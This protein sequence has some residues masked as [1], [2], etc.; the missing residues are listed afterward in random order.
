MAKELQQKGVSSKSASQ[1]GGKNGKSLSPPAYGVAMPGK[2]SIQRKKK[3][4]EDLKKKKPV[5]R[6]AK[7]DD[8]KKKKPL[9]RKKKEEDDLKKKKPI[10]RKAKPGDSALLIDAPDSPLEKEADAIAE[11]VVQH[12]SAPGSRNTARSQAPISRASA[13]AGGTGALPAPPYLASELEASRGQGQSLPGHLRSEMEGV[14]GTD[15]SGV[16]IHT[17]V[18]AAAL[19]EAVN[20]Q[21]FTYGQDVYF[22]AGMYQPGLVEG[23]RLVGHELGHVGQSL[24]NSVEFS[25][26]KNDKQSKSV[27]RKV[28][29]LK[30]SYGE[31]YSEDTLE[32]IQKSLGIESGLFEYVLSKSNFNEIDDLILKENY[33]IKGVDSIRIKAT[34]QLDKGAFWNE[35]NT[36]IMF[37]L[38]S[39]IKQNQTERSEGEM[40]YRIKINDSEF[41]IAK[42]D[43]IDFKLYIYDHFANEIKD[44]RE[45]VKIVKGSHSDFSEQ[46]HNWRGTILDHVSNYYI[47]QRPN[48]MPPLEIWNNSESLLGSATV[49]LVHFLS[50]ETPKEW[51]SHLQNFYKS[52]NEAEKSYKYAEERWHRY[53]AATIETAEDIL[54]ILEQIKKWS[55][56]TL[57]VVGS[58]YFA[59]F[60]AST[61]ATSFVSLNVLKA[62]IGVGVNTSV[63]A[64]DEVM[65]RTSESYYLG[66]DFNL[67]EMISNLGEEAFA[68]FLTNIMLSG[69]SNEFLKLLINKTGNVKLVVGELLLLLNTAINKSVIKSC[70]INVCD[71]VLKGNPMSF[72]DFLDKV[73]DRIVENLG[74]DMFMSIR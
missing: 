47:A 62:L 73:V 72:D 31:L 9:Q 4:D 63:K 58:I 33:M 70:I 29:Y 7:E 66:K 1:T 40:G 49:H 59:P 55:F 42:K 10:Q 34:F 60:A 50:A 37:E 14:I 57:K 71:E 3:E 67:T 2:I 35:G 38:A 30:F 52:I 16:R 74:K 65:T 22:N 18:K 21:A 26:K 24:N 15:L 56:I 32:Y 12:F 8:L 43:L 41:F 27:Y 64:I 6:K 36:W 5:Q 53:R 39:T 17:D 44:I 68:S 28:A 51:E 13:A 61:S 45:N 25:I 54:P 19:S 69:M 48:P 23:R 20:A 46:I 11:Q